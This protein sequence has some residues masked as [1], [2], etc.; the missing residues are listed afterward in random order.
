ME[1]YAAGERDGRKLPFYMTF[2]FSE[3]LSAESEN[4]QDM[5][6][7]AELYPP[8]A[9]RLWPLVEDTCDRWEYDGSVM[10]AQYP[11]KIRIRQE[12]G[13]LGVLMAEET[14]KDP[15]DEIQP[16]A[17]ALTDLAE[18]LLLQEICRRRCRR[19]RFRAH[20]IY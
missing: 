13:R 14:K 5:S 16:E 12:A 2:P 19:R 11:D 4:E 7:M 8:A 6:R 18:L 15:K 20:F 9:R 10:Y 3:N 1:G 17:Q